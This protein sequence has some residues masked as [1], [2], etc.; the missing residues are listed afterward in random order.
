[1]KREYM[2][3]SIGHFRGWKECFEYFINKA[4]NF[5]ILYQ[6]NKDDFSDDG[7]GLNVGKKDFSSLPKITIEKYNGMADSFI[8]SGSLTDDAI[9]LFN[10]YVSPS[11]VGSSN[12]LWSFEFLL[13]GE[14]LLQISDKSVCAIGLKDDELN[15]LVYRGVDIN[16]LELLNYPLTSLKLITTNDEVGDGIKTIAFSKEELEVFAQGIERLD[17]KN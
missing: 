6:G 9:S 5:N 13:N 3:S 11:F 10:K 16:Y 1:M 2:I 7:I 12:A 8:I 14:V 15:E 17:K 4:N